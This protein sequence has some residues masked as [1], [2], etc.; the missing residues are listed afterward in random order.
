MP[1]WPDDFELYVFPASIWIH[2]CANEDF[3]STVP[4]ASKLVLEVYVS[5]RVR[6]DKLVGRM[7]ESVESLLRQESKCQRTKSLVP[8]TKELLK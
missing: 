2:D 7:E 5:H 8:N 4:N 3:Y 6:H 1:S